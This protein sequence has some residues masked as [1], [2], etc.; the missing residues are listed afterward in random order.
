MS[1]LRNRADGVNLSDEGAVGLKEEEKLEMQLVKPLTQLQLLKEMET[2]PNVTAASNTG[3]YMLME[4]QATCSMHTC[5]GI[6]HS[7]RTY[8]EQ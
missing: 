5:T 2:T 6:K 1:H 7:V 8:F 3:I 4:E